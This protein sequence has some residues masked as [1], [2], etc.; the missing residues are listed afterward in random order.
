MYVVSAGDA[1]PSPNTYTLP[2]MLGDRVPNK[3]S[4]ACYSM[5]KRLKVG[6]FATD[7]A[8]TPGPARYEA[9]SA[10]LTQPR[11]PSYS[12]QA[13]QYMPGGM[14]VDKTPVT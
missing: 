14:V 7:Y 8:R 13:R 5:A 9:V 3:S 1:N 4:S 10:D 2:T 6:D 12:M 11:R